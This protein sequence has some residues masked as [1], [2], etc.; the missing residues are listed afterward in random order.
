[1]LWTRLRMV[2]CH[3]RRGNLLTDWIPISWSKK[4]S[5]HSVTHF[6]TG[7]VNSVAYIVGPKSSGN[8]SI[9]FSKQ[10]MLK[11]WLSHSQ[12]ATP[13]H[14]HTCSG[15]HIAWSTSEVFFRYGCETCCRVLSHFLSGPTTWFSGRARSLTERGREN[16]VAGWWLEF[17]PSPE[18]AAL[19][20]RSWCRIQL[21]LRFSSLFHRLAPR[22]CFRT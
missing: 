9:I 20:R 3:K 8:S 13:L 16:M 7:D 5:I 2:G 22:R 1:M 19:R 11:N 12:S 18:S 15:P 6:Y 4:T 10:D 21:A 14:I 17:G